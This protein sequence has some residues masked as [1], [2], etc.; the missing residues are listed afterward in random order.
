MSIP[1]G[2]A[3][4]AVDGVSESPV[5]HLEQQAPS[6]PFWEAQLHVPKT[7]AHEGKAWAAA[8][9]Q[10]RDLQGKGRVGTEQK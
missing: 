6:E 4:V 8:N 2:Y 9:A 10:A 3:E 1:E 5:P 7:S